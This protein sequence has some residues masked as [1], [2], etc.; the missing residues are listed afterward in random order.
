MKTPTSLVAAVLIAALGTDYSP[1]QSAEV[2]AGP[3]GGSLRHSSGI[4][5]ETVVSTAGI[6][7]FAIDQE[8]KDISINRG[9]GVASL[10]VPGKEKRY[11]YDLLPDGDG[12]IEAG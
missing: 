12:S 11:R 9:R 7:I 5:L 2:V 4:Q 8:G 1:A 3:H 6:R 10:R